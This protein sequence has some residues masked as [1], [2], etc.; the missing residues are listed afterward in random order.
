MCMHMVRA[1]SLILQMHIGPTHSVSHLHAPVCRIPPLEHTRAAIVSLVSFAHSLLAQNE[2]RKHGPC[3][4]RVCESGM[5][6]RGGL[7]TDL[8]VGGD[9]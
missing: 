4:P 5:G 2:D 3:G 1:I 8:G 7:D 6:G 9:S